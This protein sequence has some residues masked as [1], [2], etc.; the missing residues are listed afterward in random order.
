[1]KKMGKRIQSARESCHMTQEELGKKLGV[2]RQSICKWERGEVSAIKRSY[3]Q[4]M[5]Q[6]FGV[7]PQWLFGFDN[8]ADVELTYKALGEEPIT[9]MV[10]KHPIIGETAK[11]V[12]LYQAALAVLP[13]NLDVAIELLDS[14]SKKE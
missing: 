9:V 1:M 13:Q 3:V 8:P 7:Q 2:S 11:R 5:A 4:Q 14:L 10:D 12:Q 6:I